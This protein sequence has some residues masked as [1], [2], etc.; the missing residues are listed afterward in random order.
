MSAKSLGERHF[1]LTEPLTMEQV[2][3]L[4]TVQACVERMEHLRETANAAIATANCGLPY[5][6]QAAGAAMFG[7]VGSLLTAH[8]FCIQKRIA[9]LTR[10]QKE[11]A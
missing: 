5:M 4:H 9:L 7:R 2:N 10:Q 11:V 1:E 6:G 3:A 8:R